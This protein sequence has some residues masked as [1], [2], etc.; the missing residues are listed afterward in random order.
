MPS[1]DVD[2]EPMIL[3]PV[4]VDTLLRRLQNGC[5]RLLSTGNYGSVRIGT[6]YN[7]D[8]EAP[9]V[10]ATAQELIITLRQLIF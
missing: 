10:S 8:R 5:T 9:W 7:Y 2:L 1:S 4:D 3:Q 6:K